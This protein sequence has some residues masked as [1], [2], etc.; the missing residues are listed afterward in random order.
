MASLAKPGLSVPGK[1]SRSDCRCGPWHL[2]PSWRF[3]WA[4]RG[5]GFKFSKPSQTWYRPLRKH[6]WVLNDNSEPI[7]A[8]AASRDLKMTGS[9]GGTGYVTLSAHHTHVLAEGMLAGNAHLHLAP[10]EHGRASFEICRTSVETICPSP[11][12]I[13]TANCFGNTADRLAN[14]NQRTLRSHSAGDD[15]WTGGGGGFHWVLQSGF[16][17]RV[18][19]GVRSLRILVLGRLKAKPCFKAYATSERTRE[20]LRKKDMVWLTCNNKT[21]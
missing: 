9:Q 7:Q 1:P 19:S 8:A 10:T 3:Q 21:V 6:T 13:L 20:R 11:L 15:Q 17:F 14:K 12:W 16:G 2:K 5:T 4:K 18:L